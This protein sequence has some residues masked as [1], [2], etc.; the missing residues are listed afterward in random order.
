MDPEPASEALLSFYMSGGR[1]PRS[2]DLF[3]LGR[4]CSRITDPRSFFPDMGGP[5]SGL[6]P[7]RPF[8]LEF[9][10]RYEPSCARSK[11]L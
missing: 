9:A 2:Q 1:L 5:V 7:L 10:L 8:C 6:F 4:L 3:L 11:K